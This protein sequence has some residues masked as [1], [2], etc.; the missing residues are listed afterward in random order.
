MPLLG[1]T[2]GCYVRVGNENGRDVRT[3]ED[4]EKV[5]GILKTGSRFRLQ[6]GKK[7]SSGAPGIPGPGRIGAIRV[8]LVKNHAFGGQRVQMRR[9][10]PRVA[11]A[12]QVAEMHTTQSQNKNFH[13]RLMNRARK[14]MGVVILL[15]PRDP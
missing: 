4:R 15:L 14:F 11:V 3:S 12:S 8:M 7:V 6:D 9:A 13:P 5:R 10:N 1:V 2:L